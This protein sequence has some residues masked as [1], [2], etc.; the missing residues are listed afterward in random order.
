MTKEE[1]KKALK[2]MKEMAKEIMVSDRE[3][4]KELSKY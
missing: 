3:L 2:E 4:F 1:I